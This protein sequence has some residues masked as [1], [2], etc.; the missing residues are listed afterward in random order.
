[1][2]F[3]PVK[4]NMMQ[5]TRKLTNKIQASYILAGSFLENVE[6]IKYLGVSI[7]NVGISAIFVL[8][9]TEPLNS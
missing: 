7:T 9:L 1:M 6:N 8:T 3:Q 5:M 4:C 2:I